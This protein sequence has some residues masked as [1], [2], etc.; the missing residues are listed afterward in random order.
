MSDKFKVV[1]GWCGRFLSGDR[2]APE[3]NTSHGICDKCLARQ[4]AE[5][6]KLKKER[7]SNE[8]PSNH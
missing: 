2:N 3:E 4:N 1:C 6:E 8:Q 5:L 7:N